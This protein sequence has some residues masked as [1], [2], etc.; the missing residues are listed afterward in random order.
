[1][2]SASDSLADGLL[3]K[4]G[5]TGL[6][7]CAVLATASTRMTAET[8]KQAGEPAFK[9]STQCGVFSVD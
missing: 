8:K 5:F 7:C 6:F 9:L 1:V 3:K 2:A 4:P